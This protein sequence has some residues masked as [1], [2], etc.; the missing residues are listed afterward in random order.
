MM[1][2]ISLIIAYNRTGTSIY[3]RINCS[4]AKIMKIEK[5]SHPISGEL[6]YF[7]SEPIMEIIKAIVRNS[8]SSHSNV[9][10]SINE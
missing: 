8:Q 3:V 4:E 6:G 10:V 5:I 7:C 1:W 2:S 9:S